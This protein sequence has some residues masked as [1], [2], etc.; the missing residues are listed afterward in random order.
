MAAV[1]N[2]LLKTLPA[3]DATFTLA[4][5]REQATALRLHGLLA[6]WGEL[7]ADPESQRRVHQ[8]LRWE[9]AERSHRSLQRRLCQ[10][11][12]YSGHDGVG[13]IRPVPG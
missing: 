3:S 12:A 7:M 9:S 4:E 6:H 13:V 8:W 2:T 10:R 11:S 1:P 5:L